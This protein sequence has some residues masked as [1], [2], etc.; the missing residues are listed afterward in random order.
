MCRA[1][2]LWLATVSPATIDFSAV[3]KDYT[4]PASTEEPR[5]GRTSTIWEC[6]EAS[7]FGFKAGTRAYAQVLQLLLAYAGPDVSALL[8]S[9]SIRPK[10][11]ESDDGRHSWNLVKLGDRWLLA[12]ALWASGYK[13]NYCLFLN[14]CNTAELYLCFLMFRREI[15]KEPE[16]APGLLDPY[17]FDVLPAQFVYTHLPDA[18]SHQL[19]ATPVTAAQFETFPL[20]GRRFFSRFGL[21]L[22]THLNSRIKIV[23]VSSG[24]QISRGSYVKSAARH[25]KYAQTVGLA[26]ERDGHRGDKAQLPEAAHGPRA[27]LAEAHIRQRAGR[28]TRQR[29]HTVLL[30]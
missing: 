4:P 20:L 17:Y 12:D 15:K 14:I 1:A 11:D 5:Y 3:L 21:V 23:R 18:E 10:R 22:L 29:H 19:L 6:P 2:F 30:R 27:L 9:G 25:P 26:E 24:T 7:L 16:G 8:V 13:S 28:D